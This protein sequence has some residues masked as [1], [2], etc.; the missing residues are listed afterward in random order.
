MSQHTVTPPGFTDYMNKSSAT[1]E[2]A[3]KNAVQ[4]VGGD[5]ENDLCRYLPASNGGYMHHFTLKKMKQEQPDELREMISRFILQTEDPD[6]L[7]PKQRAPRGS[8]KKKEH[9]QLSKGAIEKL[10]NYAKQFNDQEMVTLLTPRRSLAS[11][12]KELVQMVRENRI[13][14]E[15]W[16]NY[17]QA[18]QAMQNSQHIS[19]L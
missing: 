4:K 17:V 11:Y 13:D 18:V 3:I 6:L 9:V 19:A 1:L 7:M 10:L 12:R 8:R 16:N 2:E 5:R 14:H 15:V